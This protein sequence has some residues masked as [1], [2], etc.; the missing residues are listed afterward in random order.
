MINLS[1]RGEVERFVTVLSDDYEE[2]E[3]IDF[4]EFLGALDLVNSRWSQAEQQVVLPVTAEP[5]YSEE[6]VREGRRLFLAQACSKCHGEDGKGQTRWLSHEFL[7]KQES[8]PTEEQEQI[9]YDAWNEPAPAADITARLL[10]GG[11]RPIDI[12]RRIYT[13][14]NG[15]PM[16]AFGAQFAE[17]PEQI[18]PMVHYVLHIIEGG[19]P[20]IGDETSDTAQESAANE[21][22]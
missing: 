10:H 21:S 18:W 15:T 14:I 17:T 5:A 8:L 6:T 20:R 19:D 1:K 3:E 11:R 4:E 12:Y 16:P 7:A 9:N 13:G 22:T 2:D